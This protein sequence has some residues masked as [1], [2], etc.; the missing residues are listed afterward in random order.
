MAAKKATKDVPAPDYGD[1]A[2]Y[3]VLMVNGSIDDSLFA[4]IVATVAKNKGSDKLVLA[5]VTYGGLPDRATFAVHVWGHCRFCAVI[6]QISRD[7]GGHVREQTGPF[8]V[9]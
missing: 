3:D 7:A 5:I 1:L 6:L 2:G 8:R 9:W 4:K